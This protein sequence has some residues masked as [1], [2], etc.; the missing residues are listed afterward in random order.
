MALT[1]RAFLTAS[2]AA[3]LGATARP[4]RAA[5]GVRPP[6]IVFVLTDDQRHDFLGCAGHPF[7]QT[8][9]IDALAHEGVR[10][11]NAF[12]T[13]PI[14]AAS[15]ASI[16]TGMYARSCGVHD[17]S[18]P[19]PDD[20]ISH[21]YPMEMR[22][23]GYRTG[24]VGKWGIGGPSRADEFD[25]FHDLPWGGQ[26]FDPRGET[27]QHLTSFLGDRCIDFLQGCTPDK[28]FCLSLST[29]APHAHDYAPRPF[30]PDPALEHLYVDA[31]VASPPLSDPAIF[32][33][34][35]EFLRN[36]EGRV[37]WENRFTTPEHHAETVRDYCRLIT[38]VDL[39]V[40]RI[41]DALAERG[42][43]D[44][45]IIVFSSDNGFFLGERGMAD[46]W[47]AYEDSIRVPLIIFDPRAPQHLRGRTVDAMALNIDLSPTMLAYAG[48]RIPEPVQGASLIPWMQGETP[49]WRDEWFFE[50]LF[51]RHNI[52][53]SEGLRTERYKYFRWLDTDPLLEEAYDLVTDPLETNNLALD[54]EQ[55]DLVE[56]LRAR[57]RAYRDRLPNRWS[58]R[59][60]R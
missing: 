33:A 14:C 21:T 22:S 5:S 23:A 34:L 7:L 32:E 54:P 27:A 52:P 11:T 38:G 36:S 28:P 58:N 6:N 41:Q 39:V 51:E 60:N 9:H 57:Y 37:R 59:E 50:H 13:T 26:Y 44:N 49:A 40:G 24:F 3:T 55:A 35:P 16:L 25:Y 31:E 18:T 30:P 43:A 19:I 4:A 10:F 56:D 47:Y 42:L 1:R 15:R 53:R 2:A 8:P 20:L 46:K 45:T 12:V 48:L 17:F 29:F